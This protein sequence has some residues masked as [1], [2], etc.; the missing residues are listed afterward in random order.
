MSSES[1]KLSIK[2]LNG[3]YVLPVSISHTEDQVNQLPEKLW[4]NNRSRAIL[5]YPGI[6][7]LA[8]LR[9]FIVEPEKKPCFFI[10]FL[11]HGVQLIFRYRDFHSRL[12]FMSQI[13]NPSK[14]DFQL[15]FSDLNSHYKYFASQLTD[16]EENDFVLCRSFPA[17]LC[18]TDPNKP[19][20]F[21]NSFI[22]VLSGT[23]QNFLTVP[24]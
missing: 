5:F 12:V 24:Y 9:Y 11:L 22:L 3:I 18:I 2:L 8:K 10:L 16:T 19:Y 20:F 14:V 17:V 15:L 6:S 4:H 13:A 21:L 7:Y 23:G 1:D